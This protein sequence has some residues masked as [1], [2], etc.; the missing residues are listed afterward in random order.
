MTAR[1]LVALAATLTLGAC[2]TN[3][4]QSVGKSPRRLAMAAMSA[5][6][7]PGSDGNATV[8]V[9]LDPG[10]VGLAPAE[11]GDYM[12]RQEAALRAEM[13]GTGV[14]VTRIDQQI[15]LTL[16][17]NVTFASNS[18]DIRSD[19]F[20]VLNS[21]AQVLRDYDRTVIEV[22]GHTDSTGSDWINQPASQRRADAV[23]VYLRSQRVD[24]TR[25]SSFGRGST[26]PV[27][28]NDTPVGLV[29][30]RRVEIFL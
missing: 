29:M 9:L 13:V 5:S 22:T 8:R 23:A 30:N 19:F 3:D 11:V 26:L 20:S 17:G 25:I 24:K 16:P 28:S 10:P 7:V 14:T 15:L 6:L 12:N 27:A 1:I 2:A 21:L 4:L 18:A